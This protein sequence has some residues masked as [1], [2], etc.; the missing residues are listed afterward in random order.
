MESG[1]YPFGT[2]LFLGMCGYPNG[3]PLYYGGAMIITIASQWRTWA[4]TGVEHR[5]DSSSV[6][7]LL[8]K[9]RFVCLFACLWTFILLLSRWSQWNKHSKIKFIF[10]SDDNLKH[11]ALYSLKYTI[12]NK[13]RRWQTG[14]W[15][16]SALAHT[17]SS[18]SNFFKEFMSAWASS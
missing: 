3:L 6:H 16:Q 13:R 2:L 8:K 12:L 18:F 9:N 15:S 11:I 1:L 14:L 17:C 4:G 10:P 7:C 5:W